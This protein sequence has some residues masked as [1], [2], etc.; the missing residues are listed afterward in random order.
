MQEVKCKSCGRSIKIY[1]AGK[2]AACPFC[3]TEIEFAYETPSW[4]EAEY[5]N[6]QVCPVCRGDAS[7]ILNRPHTKWKCLC[8]GYEITPKELEDVIYW[9]CD[10][11]DAFLNVQPGFDEKLGK[12]KC[13]HCGTVNDTTEDNIFD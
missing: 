1:S 5:E 11:C 10:S 13:A 9:F 4:Q 12:W 8:C 7:L 3:K 2:Y 6:S